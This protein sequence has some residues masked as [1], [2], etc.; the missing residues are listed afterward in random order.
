MGSFHIQ[1][2]ILVCCEGWVYGSGH[3]HYTYGEV[4]INQ[5]VEVKIIFPPVNYY[6]FLYFRI[7]V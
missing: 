4:L 1:I 5:N 7:D 3:L 2:L 6:F